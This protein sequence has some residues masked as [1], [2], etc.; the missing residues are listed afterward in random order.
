MTSFS[1][2]NSLFTKVNEKIF[3]ADHASVPGKSKHSHHNA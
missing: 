3:N 2:C 1:T